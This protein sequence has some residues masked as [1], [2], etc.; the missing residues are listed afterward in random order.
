MISRIRI[1]AFGTTPN[2]V[3]D[4]LHP[5]ADLIEQMLGISVGRGEEVIERDTNEPF[6]SRFAY[7]GRLNL[8]PDISENPIP[9]ADLKALQ[10]KAPTF[11]VAG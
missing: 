4:T 11:P 3:A 2:E 8:H 9:L 5:H 1:E 6:G 10:A 7:K